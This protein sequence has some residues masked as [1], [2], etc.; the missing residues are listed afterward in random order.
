MTELAESLKALS[1][2]IGSFF[3]L[4][5]LSFF[6]SGSVSLSA[7]IFWMHL[8]NQILP[9]RLEGWLKVLVI[10]LACYVNGLVCFA[11]GRW[12]R[13]PK[14]RSNRISV[15]DELFSKVLK[16]HGLADEGTFKEYIGRST[17]GGVR[18]LY[19]RLW[20]EVRQLDQL[21]PSLVVLNRYWVMA[22]TYDGLATAL[23][24]WAIV[25]SVWSAGIG[26]APPL[27]LRVGIP[28]IALLLLIAYFCLREAQRFVRNQ[29]EELVATISVQRSK[30]IR[31]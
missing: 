11:V 14:R 27:E 24:I 15:F 10:I 23:F 9:M 7:F 16:A 18:R 29:V 12:I 25:F 22:A 30:S 20:A 13:I 17:D 4:F 19:I 21:S 31:G 3:D 28:V 8:S 1:G 6:V 2:R 26:I 5:D